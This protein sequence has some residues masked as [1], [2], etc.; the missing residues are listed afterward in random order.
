[1]AF[2]GTY[3]FAVAIV[4]MHRTC[5]GDH[6]S[7]EA[8]QCP[9][10]NPDLQ[11][12]VE[13]KYGHGTDKRAVIAE[14]PRQAN[15]AVEVAFNSVA[16]FQTKLTLSKGGPGFKAKELRLRFW[17]HR[18]GTPYKSGEQILR[19]SY[20]LS[21]AF[22]PLSECSALV[23]LQ[24][25][26]RVVVHLQVE[27]T[28]V[29]EL[30][31]RGGLLGGCCVS[32]K[33]PPPQL[34][35]AGRRKLAAQLAAC[36]AALA[37]VLKRWA[38]PWL[39]PPAS[40]RRGRP[41]QLVRCTYPRG[42]RLHYRC[43]AGPFAPEITGHPVPVDAAPP[44]YVYY[45]GA[46]SAPGMVRCLVPAQR[47][48]EAPT[49]RAV[50]LEQGF[51]AECTA[52]ALGCGDENPL[53]GLA[54]RAV[55]PVPTATAALSAAP[56]L[57][58]RGGMEVDP[59]MTE[60]YSPTEADTPPERPRF[61]RGDSRSNLLEH[62]QPDPPRPRAALSPMLAAPAPGRSSPYHAGTAPP[63][64]P[65]A[66]SDAPAAEEAEPD[67]RGRS[68]LRRGIAGAVR[69]AQRVAE[70]A[71]SGSAPRLCAGRRGP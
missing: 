42:T 50:L 69:A 27:A 17:R 71:R 39:E 15:R 48:H 22:P 4:A 30:W 25:Q 38:A 24:Q 1:M 5:V 21:R 18:R 34:P 26:P 67:A 28:L 10:A 41:P 53:E 8:E 49:G 35:A 44:V 59:E 56:D 68:L 45:V 46:G 55:S 63:Q 13:W 51:E 14:A 60:P 43:D 31:K 70:R 2:A 3:D 57:D 20:D 6:P 54:S 47:F 66:D 19:S 58:A 29:A 52:A 16:R 7:V 64:P 33:E 65:A 11:W 9:W 12:S 32:R 40:G 62:G 36:G 37:A 23:Q 61:E